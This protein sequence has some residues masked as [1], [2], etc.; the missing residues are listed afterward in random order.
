MASSSN[1]AFNV[2][3][4]KVNDLGE[5]VKKKAIARAQHNNN[6][7]SK[8]KELV[9]K[10]QGCKEHINKVRE[11]LNNC[12][13]NLESS[14]N[15]ALMS[16][17]KARSDIRTAIERERKTILEQQGLV[18]EQAKKNANMEAQEKLIRATNDFERLAE[19]LSEILNTIDKV[20]NISMGE[21]ETEIN[22]ICSAAGS[23]AETEST[24]TGYPAGREDSSMHGGYRYSMSKTRKNNSLSRKNNSLSRKNNSLSR[25][26][27][28]L[29]RKNNS[30]SA[31][32]VKK[33]KTKKTRK[34]R[35]KR[36]HKKK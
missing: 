13:Q 24:L 5:E 9:V 1:N 10:L 11:D 16:A 33:T 14:K 19:S 32:R 15:E 18:V 2:A 31:G 7:N 23:A 35:K 29:S 4:K 20:G 36:H 30:L 3:L 12:K 27:N 8:V 25:K 34:H 17:E 6:V 22:E 21:L 26:N 28:S